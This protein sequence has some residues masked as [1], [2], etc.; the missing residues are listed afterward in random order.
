MR[1]P[2]PIRV[3]REV[4]IWISLGDGYPSIEGWR[5]VGMDDARAKYRWSE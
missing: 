2:R 5:L 1:V 3:P 4:L